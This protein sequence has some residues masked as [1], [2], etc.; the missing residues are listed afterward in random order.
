MWGR[1]SV[2]FVYQ[3]FALLVA[4]VVVHA[5][6]VGVVRP[7][8]RADDAAH[9]AAV[10][11][12]APAAA[13]QRSVWIVIRNY[14]QEICFMLM[15]WALALL[16]YKAAGVIGE[17][18]LLE[19]DLLPVGAGES[20]LPQDSRE[21][22]RAIESLPGRQRE[23]LYPRALLTAL[24]RFRSTRNVQDVSNA[25]SDVCEAE[26]DRLDSELSMVRYIAWAIPSIG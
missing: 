5:L 9:I 17:R 22:A 19:Q 14:E 3:L 11:A 6:Y 21:Y 2:E 12:D 13:Q 7:Q 26:T 8:A 10:A 24:H 15:V 4:V 18:R 16:A 20:V 23:Y 25:V 1:L